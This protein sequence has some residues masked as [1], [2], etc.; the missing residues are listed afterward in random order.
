MDGQP[1]AGVV[2][3]FYPQGEGNASSGTTNESGEYTLQY[4]ADKEGAIIGDHEVRIVTAP[5]DNL[6]APAEETIPAKY[7]SESTL[8]ET[9]ADENNTFDF[10][11]EAN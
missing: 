10:Q 6:D 9:V 1:L 11:L 5:S 8:T 7:N 4:T 2:V 3:T